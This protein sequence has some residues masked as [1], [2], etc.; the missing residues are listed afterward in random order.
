MHFVQSISSHKY[1]YTVYN[2][3]YIPNH[4]IINNRI[5]LHLSRTSTNATHLHES[6]EH[7]RQLSC[8]QLGSNLRRCKKDC[9][10]ARLSI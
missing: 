8:I 3:I 1:V 2:N 6:V 7:Q 10:L 4:K 5:S 9:V